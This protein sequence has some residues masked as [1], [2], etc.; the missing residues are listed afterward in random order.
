MIIV[1]YLKPYNC[2][3][4][5]ENSPMGKAEQSRERSSALPSTSV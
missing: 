3:M 1:S 4:W 2:G 5:F